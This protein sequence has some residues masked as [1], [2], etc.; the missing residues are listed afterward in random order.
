M[1]GLDSLKKISLEKKSAIVFV[2]ATAISSGLNMVTTPFF[3][4]LMPVDSF[5]VVQLFNTWYQILA[6]FATF[7]VTNA[8]IN[9][10][11]HNYTND[12]MGYLSSSL[13]FATVST[14]I[15]V[16]LVFL[17]QGWFTKVSGLNISLIIL[18]ALSFLFLNS[19]RLWIC[20]QRYELKYKKV[21]FVMTLSGIISTIISLIAVYLVDD[22][23][24]EARLW[25]VNAIP[26]I[27]G[28]VLYIYICL[29]GKKFYNKKYWT[30]ILTFNAPL[31][32]HYLSQFILA[33]SDRLMINYYCNEADV[34]IYSLA[35]LVSNILLVFFSPINSVIIPY[36]HKLFDAGN[37]T[38]IENFLCKLLIGTGI[39]IFIISL[40]SPEVVSVLGGKQYMDGIKIVPVVSL[41]TLFN[42]LYIFVANI[43]F[44]YGKTHKIALM[45]I[46]AALLNILLNALLIPIFG[47]AAAAYTTLI[48]YIVY[49]ILHIYNMQKLC[50]HRI[51]SHKKLFVICFSCFFLCMTTVFISE[52]I[53]IRYIL[54][55]ACI[56]IFPYIYKKSKLKFDNI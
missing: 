8:I 35:Y 12:R 23:Y 2:F 21:F 54:L 36:T 56:I 1:N 39:I 20:L 16:S 24:A 42:V 25:S 52:M 48:A 53:I 28:I 26:I 10:G 55:A 29:K 5:G 7:S 18:M 37:Y 34:A 38:A 11:F 50:K 4:R 51:F 30:F 40:L 41:S 19:T 13:G 45:T 49:A 6:V 43:E 32:I 27:V 3:T 33:G 44:L 14:L 9:V 15:I 31:L 46:I 47:F 22:H 17:A